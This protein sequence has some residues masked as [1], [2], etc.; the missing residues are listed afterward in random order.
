MQS[1]DREPPDGDYSDSPEGPAAEQGEALS[2]EE[3]AEGARVLIADDNEDAAT[4]LG[5]YLELCGCEVAIAHDGR[6]A[7][8]LAERFR[9][10]LAVID[11]GMPHLNGF[12]CARELRRRPWCDDVLLVALTGWGQEQDRKRSREA[13]FDDHLVKP[14]EPDVISRLLNRRRGAPYSSDER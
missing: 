11:L 5:M 14:V 10:K 7:V 1:S 8:E 13:G 9:P 12:D 3:P 2:R 6:A 4:M